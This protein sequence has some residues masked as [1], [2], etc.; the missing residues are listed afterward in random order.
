[1]GLLPRIPYRC[2]AFITSLMAR[3]TFMFLWKY[4]RRMEANVEKALGH[5][6][7]DPRERKRLV[8]RA[9]NNFALGM[10]DTMAV[11]HMSKERIAASIGIEGEEHLQ[12]ALAKGKGVIALSAHLGAFT[13]IGGRLAAVGYPFSIVVK[14]PADERMARIINNY[15]TQLGIST[16][17]AK[18]RQEAVRGILQALRQNGIVLVIADEFKSGGV[19]ISFMGQKAAAPRGPASLALRTGAA[20]L[21]MFAAR[22]TDGSVVLRIGSEIELVRHGDV[23]TSIA[24]TTRLFTHH[25]EEAVRRFPDQWNWFGF[26][27]SNRVSRAEYLRRHREAKKAA[28]AA[29]QEN[30]HKG[31]K[32]LS[33]DRKEV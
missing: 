21:P 27:R 28:A 11:M 13:M 17:S 26:P 2:S 12:R 15:R 3:F 6:I 25:I 33:Q 19:E 14:H 8:R 23:E 9:W 10:L 32:I 29:A 4:R 24:E 18:P 1:M 30:S 7:A 20:T 5:H 31:R 16:I 22:A